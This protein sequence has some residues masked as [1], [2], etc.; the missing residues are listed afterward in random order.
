MP[1]QDRS[2]FRI[3]G[4]RRLMA[5]APLTC[6]LLSASLPAGEP[7][8]G[9]LA[10]AELHRRAANVEEAKKL[11][12][13]GDEAYLSRKWQDAATAYASARELIPDA[14][15]TRE[16]RVAATERY[17]Q[18]AVERSREQSRLGDVAGAGETIDA[19]LDK[20]V[21]PNHPSALAMRAELDDPIRTNPALDKEHIS[22]VEEV[23]FLLYQAEGA[24]NLGDFDKA[25]RIYES[26]LRTDPTN[27]AARRGLERTAQ[28]RAD[29]S[30][31][32]QDS[33]RATMLAEVDAA[34]ELPIHPAIDVPVDPELGVERTSTVY[35]SEKLDRIII[36]TVNFEDVSIEE[37][38]DFLRGQSIA[39]DNLEADPARRGVNFVLNLGPVDSEAGA[40]V[41]ATRIN[42]R[43]RN[44]PISQVLSYIGD[45]TRTTYSPQ[46]WAVVIQSADAAATEMVSRTF[47]VPPDF[48]SVGNTGGGESSS[49]PFGGGEQREGLLSRRMTAEE[50]LKAQGVTFPEG[51]SAHLNIANGT[52]QV[53]NTLAN[54]QFIEQIVETMLSTEP[55]LAIV[56]VKF[57]RVRETHHEELGFD[58]II[59]EIGLG[60]EGAAPGSEALFLTGGTQDPENFAD[61]ALASGE[62]FR[63]SVTSGNRSGAEAISSNSLDGLLQETGGFSP[64]AA[65][66]PGI[67]GITKILDRGS[68]STMMRG[69]SQKK[70]VDLAANPSVVVRD[71]QQASI[72]I[73]RE[74]L[75]PTEYE[76]P[77]LPNSVG[78]DDV[79]VDFDTGDLFGG[80][81]PLT[82]ITPATPTSFDKREVGVLLDVL[83]TISADRNYID[84]TIKPEVTDF[85]GFVNFGTPITS[86]SSSAIDSVFNPGSRV[87]E[88]TPNEILMPVFSKL[89]TPD[90]NITI[91]NGATIVI[92]GLLQ[93]K[94]QKVDDKTPIL[95]DIPF[96]GRLFRT[97]AYAPERTAVAIMVTVRVVDPSGR[98]FGRN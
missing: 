52:L 78:S 76:P 7:G 13:Q 30:R 86:P 59:S 22:D 26:V 89:A 47:R 91:Q 15:A 83:P 77:E 32:A 8:S 58:T 56:E 95:G 81:T 37:A 80:G 36:P 41:R 28:A 71:G 98:E 84:L 40:A 9:G 53:R 64:A 10:Q 51:A 46:D 94:I 6:L 39:L 48:L 11:L 55:A 29:Y 5:L 17:V 63:R 87:V 79:F 34:W 43:L 50:V 4:R 75:Y 60:G 16:L 70:G 90:L 88:L 61:M 31:A 67:L 2:I 14:P 69:L 25:R 72:R 1:I 45:I 38:V 65:R 66:A 96:V 82:P 92:G 54:V 73:V 18:A 57:I 85:D 93:D 35:L 12:E 44:V 27:K 19:V 20:A 23:R 21:A 74:L 68:V 62:Y 49:D 3:S 42:L 24:Y 33:T 97:S